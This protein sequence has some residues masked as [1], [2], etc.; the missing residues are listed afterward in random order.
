[1]ISNLVSFGQFGGILQVTKT[2]IEDATIDGDKPLF[3]DE[4]A[5]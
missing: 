3:G 2:S 5:N 1:M 4:N